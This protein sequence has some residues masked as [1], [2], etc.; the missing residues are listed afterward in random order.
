MH[1]PLH[2]YQRL[3]SV[4]PS[5]AAIFHQ[6]LDARCFLARLHQSRVVQAV[7]IACPDCGEL[8]LILLNR[9]GIRVIFLLN[10]RGPPCRQMRVKYH[11]ATIR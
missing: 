5:A 7:S 11:A 6:T 1:S 9:N 10:E 4:S 3:D 2:F 8:S